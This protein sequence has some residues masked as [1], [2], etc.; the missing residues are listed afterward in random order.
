MIPDLRKKVEDW[1]NSESSP[2]ALQRG[3]VRVER[4]LNW[5]GF[6]TS[7]FRATDGN[8]T[9][10]LKLGRAPEQEPMRRWMAVHERLDQ[11]AILG[12]PRRRA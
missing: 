7:S 9:V 2:A 12:P 5:G 10:H 1:L 8:R 6:V 4:V 11:T 3:Q